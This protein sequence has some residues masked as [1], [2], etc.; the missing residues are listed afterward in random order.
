MVDETNAGNELAT[1]KITD[2]ELARVD[3]LLQRIRQIFRG[4]VVGQDGL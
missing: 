2:T 3:E 4:R 1:G